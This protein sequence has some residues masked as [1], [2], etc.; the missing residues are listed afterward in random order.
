[1]V[2]IA[3]A[4]N[5]GLSSYQADFDA[6]SDNE[7]FFPGLTFPGD[8]TFD[9]DS[10][11]PLFFGRVIHDFDAR[12]GS[13]KDFFQRIT[14][15][16]GTR[17]LISLQWDSPFFSAT[18]SVGTA[19]DIDVYILDQPVDDD[20]DFIGPTKIVGGSSEANIGT[21]GDAVEIVEFFNPIDP[22]TT[23]FNIM[24]VHSRSKQTADPNDTTLIGPAPGL[25]KYVTFLGP[26]AIDEHNQDTGSIFGQAAANGAL[27]VGA[28]DYRTPGIAEDFSSSGPVKILF[29]VTGTRLETPLARQKPD[30]VGPD[31]VNIPDTT[32]VGVPDPIDGLPNYFGTSAAAAHVA[33]VAALI[34]EASPSISPE[35]LL[36]A[37]RSSATDMLPEGFDDDSGHG[38]VQA[39]AAISLLVELPVIADLSIT[40]QASLENA[41]VVAPVT[42]VITVSNDGLATSTN[43][44]VVDDLPDELAF[45]DIAP[46]PFLCDEVEEVVSCV[47]LSLSA[48]QSA[49]T[50]ITAIVTQEGTISNTAS[51]SGDQT[52]PDISNNSAVV[53]IE[54]S[55][56]PLPDLTLTK[57]DLQ[58]PITVGGQITYVISVANQGTGE[59]TGVSMTDSLPE[60]TIFVSASVTQGTCNDA[61]GVVTCQ[62]GQLNVD[63]SATSTIVV[64]TVST[65]VLSNTATASSNET[66]LDDTDNTDSEDTAVNPT[67]EPTVVPTAIVIETP[68]PTPVP[69]AMP[70]TPVPTA[71]PGPVT[72]QSIEAK[73]V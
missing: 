59:A 16:N 18:G 58:D 71:T 36:E 56:V 66:D 24:V 9:P 14:V 12:P 5:G 35:A 54:A 67:P 44:L 72:P 38:L 55:E 21:T 48:G 6:G 26:L 8:P 27:S 61:E 42:F 65:G 39:H 57:T 50:T 23:T 29:D 22:G 46:G 40:K 2:Y 52:D 41:D 13:D 62:L 63:Q 25:F 19:N 73:T 15:P 53:Q 70:P 51:V 33:G 17:A 43:I 64:I 31:G 69:T 45:T 20:G 32:L 37:M 7:N 34:K 10:D 3:S 47:L 30:L 49:T 11:P 60:Q 1:M 28:A 68:V 4:G